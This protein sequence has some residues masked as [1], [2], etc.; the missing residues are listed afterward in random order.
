MKK[1]SEK[2]I[3]NKSKGKF[4]LFSSDCINWKV[5]SAFTDDFVFF[6]SVLPQLFVKLGI[7]NQKDKNV[8]KNGLIQMGK[9]CYSPTETYKIVEFDINALISDDIGDL[10][11][12]SP[13]KVDE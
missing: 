7:K 6:E 13:E 5:I 1:L 4:L 11:L 3:P 12:I 8:I 9:C 10:T 2:Y